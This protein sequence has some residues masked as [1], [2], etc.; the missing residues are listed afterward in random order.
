MIKKYWFWIVGVIS[1][2]AILSALIAEYIYFL[3]PCTMCLKQR[4]PYYLIIVI[5]FIFILLKWQKKIL[6][7]YIVQAAS[8]Y[9]LF[10]S[11]WHVA[12]EQ[13]LLKGPA[14]CSIS[15]NTSESTKKLKEQIMSKDVI[16]CEDIVWEFFGFSAASINSILLLLIFL[17]NAI[18]LFRYYEAKKNKKI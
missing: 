17:F 10:Y 2:F 3:E 7:Y 4:Y 11:I 1:I 14:N 8:V 12:I 16:S 5:F 13:K 15:L 9:G 6:F 18:Y